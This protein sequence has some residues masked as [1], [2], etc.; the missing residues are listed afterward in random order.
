[1]INQTTQNFGYNIE[2]FTLDIN[3]PLMT[4][5]SN[6]NQPFIIGNANTKCISNMIIAD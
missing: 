2:K 3:T 4:R 1:L 5:V 6:N